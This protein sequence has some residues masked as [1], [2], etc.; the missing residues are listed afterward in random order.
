[1]TRESSDPRKRVLV[2]IVAYNAE[3]TIEEVVRRIPH[4]LAEHDTEVL[5][6]DDS[7][8]DGTFARAHVL[9]QHADAPF[10][11]TVL[12]NPVNQ[13]Y[14]GNQK[15]GFHYA[16]EKKFDYVALV[17]GD[18][19]YAPERL[20]ELLQ[21]LLMEEAD[22]VFG[23]RMMKS[24]EALK[25]GMPLYKY[26]GNKILT[27]IQNRLL[28]SSLTEFHSGY[29]L[30]STRA[31]QAIPFDRNVNDFHFDTE[32]IIQLMRAGLRIREVPIPTY[33]GD[34]ICHVNGIKYAWDVV[35]TT[36]L[37]QVQDL[38]V[39]Y[40]RKFDVSS[41]NENNPLYQP[42]FGFESPHSLAVERV[43]EGSSVLDIGCASGYVSAAL[44]KKHCR[45]TG[46]D[47]FPV[48]PSAELD[49]FVQHNLDR[50]DLPVDAGE[51]DYVLLLDV[52]EHLRSPEEFVEG[53]RRSRK[54]DRETTLIVSTGN[55]A[56][57]ITRF[58]LLLGF[59][60]YGS[61][62]ILDLTHTRLFTFG[63]LRR[64]LEQAGY[65]I[66][67]VRGVPAPFPLALGDNVLGKAV[68]A[69]NRL[70]I[71]LSK[72][73]FAYQIFI[74]ARPQPALPWLLKRAVETREQRVCSASRP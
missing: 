64:L 17:H 38:G 74:V 49:R 54:E 39:F 55:V 37:A 73:L 23:S 65:S 72:S 4:T 20:P 31:L 2:F 66:E 21:P 15:I 6:I 60:N 44:K 57:C 22:A 51:F 13:G 1:M 71:R 63:S 70:L 35:M 25:G 14:G 42:K 48:S 36:L 47:Q 59:F 26:V 43:S 32:I 67:E 7:S 52:I 10:P 27:G 45:I 50:P 18:G 56:F 61:R 16:I 11:L 68:L 40:N 62:G 30:Y 19:Q 58:M 24:G 53:L 69:L 46:I 28:H 33:Y 41:R 5:I 8:Q 9:E 34:E 29:R 12:F 3:K